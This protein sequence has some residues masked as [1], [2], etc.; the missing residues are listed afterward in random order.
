MRGFRGPGLTDRGT[1][2]RRRG[3]PDGA[4]TQ[5]WTKHVR[6]RMRMRMRMTLRKL[7]RMNLR[8][9]MPMHVQ[10]NNMR[11]I[12]N[13]KDAAGVVVHQA[14]ARDRATCVPAYVVTA[15]SG[16]EDAGHL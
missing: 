16:D 5:T 13:R 2:G 6:M 10:L 4:A 9:L 3:V 1:A 15:M 7:M 8:K 14:R 12:R 11:A